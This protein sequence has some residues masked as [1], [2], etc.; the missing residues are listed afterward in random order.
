MRQINELG[1][2]VRKGEK[3]T[4]VVFWR[5]YVDGVEVKA[6]E[7]E[8][9]AQEA[10][11]QGRR[12]F[13]LRY[14]SIFNTEQCELPA[15]IAETVILPEQRQLNPIEACEAM[16]AGMPNP[17]QIVHAGDKAFYSPMTD[18]ITMPPRGLFENAEEYWSTLW[19]E[20]GHAVGHPRRLNRESIKEVAPFGSAT[21]SAEEIVAEMTAAY[22]CGITGIENRTIDNSAAYIAGWIKQLRDQRKLIIHAAAQAQRACDY[23]LNLKP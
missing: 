21:Y 17:P 23:I 9:E 7:P 2:Q 18:R 19:H 20:E 11:G 22:L 12:R 1:G 5:I 15:T 6:G 14:Y 16:L 4:P 8:P 13:V 10:E 3:A